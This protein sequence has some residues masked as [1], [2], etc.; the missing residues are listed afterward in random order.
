M[1]YI[2]YYFFELKKCYYSVV[3][4]TFIFKIMPD[5]KFKKIYLRI[6]TFNKRIILRCYQTG[7][8]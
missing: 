6:K 5:N 2:D 7:F 8:G 3:D 1:R 4:M